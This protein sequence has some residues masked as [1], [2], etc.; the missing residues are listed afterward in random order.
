MKRKFIRTIATTICILMLVLCFAACSGKDT[1]TSSTEVNS[2][3][4]LANEETKSPL[5]G[6]W[7]A[8]EAE[9]MSYVFNEDGT[10]KW[11]AGDYALDFEFVDKGNS[12]EIT[13]KGA[14]DAQTW[15]YTIS[16]STLSMKDA[17]SGTTLTYTKK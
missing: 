13:Y 10:G 1:N 8:N 16:D 2:N 5:I 15:E 3:T 7:A 4:T 6:T 14:T 11:D 17:D 9:G 12:V